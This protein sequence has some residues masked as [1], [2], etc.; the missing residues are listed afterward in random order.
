MSFSSNTALKK[1]ILREHGD[2]HTRRERHAAQR[3]RRR[4]RSRADEALGDEDSGNDVDDTIRG[5]QVGRCDLR[6]LAI[7]GEGRVR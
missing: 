7:E 4:R 3:T 2:G 1:E 6:G 5:Q